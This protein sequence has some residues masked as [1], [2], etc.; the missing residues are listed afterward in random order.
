MYT[1]SSSAKIRVNGGEGGYNGDET[2]LRIW[3]LREDDNMRNIIQILKQE[4]G[5]LYY[6]RAGVHSF[7]ILFIQTL[8]EMYAVFGK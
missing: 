5:F 1:I 8:L 7:I 6:I 2:K 3:H 4:N